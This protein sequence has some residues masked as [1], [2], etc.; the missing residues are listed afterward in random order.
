MSGH[1]KKPAGR[2]A[3]TC[4][5]R[6]EGLVRTRKE[7]NE[8]RALTC[9]RRRTEGLVRTWIETDRPRH[10]HQLETA[11]G[12]TCQDTERNWPTEAHSLPGDGRGRELSGHGRKTD[13]PRRTH[14]LE[15]EDGGSCQDMEKHRPTEAHS[16]TGESTGRSLSGHRKKLTNRGALTSW[17]WQ[18]EGPI[19]TWKE[20]DQPRRAHSLEM[21][22]GGDLSG[23]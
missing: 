18:R 4:W 15:T 11:D 16:P 7:T 17:R 20:T 1:G 14:F 5:R 19:R 9:W 2:G 6:Q 10:T 8:R 23:H 21:A 13:R 12:G 3:L 22:E